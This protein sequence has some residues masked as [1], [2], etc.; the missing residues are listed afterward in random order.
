MAH[1]LG[2]LYAVTPDREDTRGLLASV[3]EALA[4]G[5]ALLQYRNK[6]A[7]P[8]L[9]LEQARA[10]AALCRRY[11][12]PLVINDDVDLALEVNAAG[13]HLGATDGSLTQAR[14]RLGPD[15]ILGAS[16]YA[17]LENAVHAQRA[18]VDY[19]AFGSFFSSTVKPDAVRAPLA[20]LGEARRT[21]GVPVM[22]IGGITLE[23]AGRLV[24][25]GADGVAVISALFDAPDVRA[26]A[27]AFR[28]LF[29]A[30]HHEAQS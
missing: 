5:A 17:Q 22:A 8:A 16:C 28:S 9:R 26:A 2:G 25:A 15:R 13:A 20:L 21:L 30:V 6:R 23:R 14:A 7:T 24:A 3:E 19:V 18:G 10:L 29:E 27:A 1:R 11:A 12:V 4:G